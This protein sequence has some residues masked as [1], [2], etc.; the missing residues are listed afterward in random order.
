MPY[1][2]VKI[3]G[4]PGRQRS[5]PAGFVQKD[6]GPASYDLGHL[7]RE[8][9]AFSADGNGCHLQGAEMSAR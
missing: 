2:Q 6:R 9:E 3:E 8:G 5:W 4:C 1:D 7:H